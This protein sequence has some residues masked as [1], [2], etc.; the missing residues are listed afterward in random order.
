MGRVLLFG[1][2]E[3][4]EK[5]K[6]MDPEF[7]Q[8]ADRAQLFEATSKPGLNPDEA[9]EQEILASGASHVVFV[10]GAGRFF[11]HTSFAFDRRFFPSDEQTVA[12][13]ES[14]GPAQLRD[15]VRH[16][17]F[18]P[19]LLGHLCDEMGLIFIL[20]EEEEEEEEREEEISPAN[21]AKSRYKVV[22]H[23]AGLLDGMRSDPKRN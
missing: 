10:H 2:H 21:E 12:G 9:V 3:S 5:A 11:P 14:G 13:W 22:R 1:S 23:F 8:L 6:V 4:I 16:N 18:A 15:N 19:W 20:L 7:Q 17:L